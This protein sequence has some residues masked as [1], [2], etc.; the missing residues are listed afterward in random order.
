MSH[1]GQIVSALTS[2]KHQSSIYPIS[3]QVVDSPSTPAQIAQNLNAAFLQSLSGDE[4]AIK[5]LKNYQVDEIWANTANFYLNTLEELL[6]EFEQLASTDKDFN[7]AVF[8]LL[9]AIES[10]DSISQD[11]WRELIWQVFFP[12]GCN[13]LQAPEYAIEK[14]TQDREVTIKQQASGITSP[15]KQIL[16]TSNALITVPLQ[17]TDINSLDYSILICQVCSGYQKCHSSIQDLDP[18]HLKI[19]PA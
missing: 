4:S 17:E 12:D 13:P 11:E 16:L 8:Q 5:Y 9:N 7:Q 19:Y 3:E 15:A 1:L 14:L 18:G 2:A 6:K 10:S